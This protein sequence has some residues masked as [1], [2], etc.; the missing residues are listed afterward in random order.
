VAPPA[1]VGALA[2]AARAALESSELAARLRRQGL[3]RAAE[4][5]WERTVA[6]YAQVY[7]MVTEEARQ[8][9][10]EN[11]RERQAACVR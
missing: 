9:Q 4:Y 7:E 2:A 5:T 3:K 8:R 11:E 1:D 6:G 10:Q